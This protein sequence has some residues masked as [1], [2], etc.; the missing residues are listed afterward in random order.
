MLST[1]LDEFYNEGAS[2]FLIQRGAHDELRAL[3]AK[4]EWVKNRHSEAKNVLPWSMYSHLGKSR[5]PIPEAYR[6]VFRK[7]ADDPKV[8]GSLLNVYR[9]DITLVDCWNGSEDLDWHWD[10]ADSLIKYAP[11]GSDSPKFCE[12]FFLVYLSEHNNWQPEMGGG[13][14]YAKRALHKADISEAVEITGIDHSTSKIVY[15]RNRQAILVNNMNPSFI[16]RSMKMPN[17]PDGSKP[18]RIVFQVGLA[19]HPRHLE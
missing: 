8:M 5:P 17:R 2:P 18:D 12:L 3:L 7:M 15:P 6:E 11:T 16:H 10:G 13:F 14:E 1:N 9:F 4:E 19:T